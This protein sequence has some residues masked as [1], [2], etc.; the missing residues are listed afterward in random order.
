MVDFIENSSLEVVMSLSVRGS[1]HQVA[2]ILSWEV[3]R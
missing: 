2:Q 3:Y 1:M